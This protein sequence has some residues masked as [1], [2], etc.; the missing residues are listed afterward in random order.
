MNEEKQTYFGEL[1]D[2]DFTKRKKPFGIVAAVLLLGAVAGS[3]AMGIVNKGTFY[4]PANTVANSEIFL[5]MDTTAEENSV[6]ESETREQFMTVADTFEVNGK[7]L[8]SYMKNGTMELYNRSDVVTTKNG[9]TTIYYSYYV[10]TLTKSFTGEET[11]TYAG[12]TYKLSEFLSN[13]HV[14]D[15]GLNN[16]IKLSFKNSTVVSK[17]QPAFAP[18]MISTLVG[19]A[20]A[21]AYLLL[22][23][24]LS[25][26]LATLLVTLGAGAV[27]AALFII[28]PLSVG[29]YVLVAT[30]IVCLLTF[31]IEIMLMNKEREMI[32]ED[33]KHDNSIENRNQIMVDATRYTCT[34]VITLLITLAFLLIDFMAIGPF[35]TCYIYVNVLVGLTLA[36][37]A[38]LA[39]FG[40]IAQFFYKAFFGVKIERPTNKKK[41]K[42]AKAVH[43]SAEPEEAIFIGIND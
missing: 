15:L 21:T 8:K 1:S 32:N 42:K 25:R 19:V 4:K 43:K 13:D 7:T 10:V 11:A 34:P 24:R 5:E 14:T 28:V 16:Q 22:R 12:N 6:L 17:D 29:S 37:F 40:P 26:G 9:N 35:A 2:V 31:M 23:Y 3:V 20:V 30:P 38:V 39:L 36:T 27:T 33:K 18:V 41:A